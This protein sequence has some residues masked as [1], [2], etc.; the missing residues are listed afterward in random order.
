MMVAARTVPMAGAKSD[1]HRSEA[2]PRGCTAAG[3]A[4]VESARCRGRRGRTADRAARPSWL[5]RARRAIS[6]SSSLLMTAI[7]RWRRV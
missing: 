7:R 2:Y 6:T 1:S 3:P 4:R 5:L